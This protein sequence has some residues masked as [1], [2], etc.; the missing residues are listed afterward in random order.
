MQSFFTEDPELVQK[1]LILEQRSVRLQQASSTLS[2]IQVVST[3]QPSLMSLFSSPTNY[4][5]SNSNSGTVMNDG[6]S[7]EETRLS[8]TITIGI[9]GIGLIVANDSNDSSN[10]QQMVV[11]ELRKMPNGITNPSELA[12]VKI[13]DIVEMINGIYPKSLQDAVNMLKN[14]KDTVTLSVIRKM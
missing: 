3:N 10:N 4:N 14:V 5:I 6:K 12:G 7:I 11:K 2:Q 9:Y 13:G 1:R 8:L